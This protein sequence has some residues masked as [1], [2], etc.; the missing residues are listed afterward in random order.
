[1]ERI[2]TTLNTFIYYALTQS[3]SS[4]TATSGAPTSPVPA[5]DVM[6]TIVMV[7]IFFAIMYFLIIRPQKKREKDAQVM[8]QALEVGHDIVTIGG[9]IGTVVSMKED[10]VVI[11]T[12][13][14]R[15]KIRIYRWAIQQNIT[16]PPAHKE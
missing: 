14:D 16:P 5:P 15:N 8:R 12:S 3:G 4:A 13:G 11:E 1:M 9:I 6:S 7:A 2:L 10:T